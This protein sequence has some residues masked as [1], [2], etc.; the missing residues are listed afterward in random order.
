MHYIKYICF[1]GYI[2]KTLNIDESILRGKFFTFRRKK[3]LTSSKLAKKIGLD[4][5]TLIR[6]EKNEAVKL[7]AKYRIENHLTL[8]Y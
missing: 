8:K 7:E 5:S 6:F 1:W 4:K 2:P 3:E